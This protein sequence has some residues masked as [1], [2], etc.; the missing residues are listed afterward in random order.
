MINT[1]LGGKFSREENG[2]FDL[3]KHLISSGINIEFPFSDGIVGEYKGIGVTFI[4]TPERT[5]YDIEIEFFNA[6]RIN[7]VHIVHNK[8]KDQIG[9]IGESASIELGYAIMHNR[10]IIF[11]YEPTFSEKVS[12]IIKELINANVELIKIKRLDLLS[13]D[14]VSDYVSTIVT[15]P[16]EYLLKVTSEVEVMKIVGNLLDSY[17]ETN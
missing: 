2:L 4:P 13:T 16:I 3:R 11:L 7:P 9:Y 1:Q 8:F 15:D 14:E 12:P 10:P 5:F 6:I 17:K